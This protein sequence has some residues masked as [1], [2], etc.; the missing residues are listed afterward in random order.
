MSCWDG[1]VFVVVYATMRN[2]GKGE[3][4]VMAAGRTLG[5]TLEI[6]QLDVCDEI[7]IRACVDSLP[8]RRVDIL[9]QSLSSRLIRCDLLRPH[10]SLCSPSQQ[11]WDGSNWTHRVSD[12]GRDEDGDGH[13]LLWAGEAGEG[14]PPRYEEEKERTHCCRQQRDGNPR[15]VVSFRSP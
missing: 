15:W 5:R 14:N 10:G 11:R 3:A 12:N 6:K 9:S 7:S 2:L 4:L 13:Q 8:D 1:H